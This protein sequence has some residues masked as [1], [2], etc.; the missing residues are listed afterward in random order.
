M[1]KG[2]IIVCYIRH[3]GGMALC[4]LYTLIL[5]MLRAVIILTSIQFAF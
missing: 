2:Y 1:R 5:I 3:N 4:A